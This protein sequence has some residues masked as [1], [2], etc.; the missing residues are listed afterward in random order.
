[1]TQQS[2]IA[3]R[4]RS[5]ARFVIEHYMPEPV[6]SVAREPGALESIEKIMGDFPDQSAIA[7][8]DRKIAEGAEIIFGSGIARAAAFTRRGGQG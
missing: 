3:A 7:D 2:N 5:L 6:A 1:M 4:R 8:L